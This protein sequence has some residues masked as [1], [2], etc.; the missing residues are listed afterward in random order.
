MEEEVK[1]IGFFK[2]IKISI[3][4]LEQY[5]IFTKESFSKA[6]KYLLLLVVIV[7]IILGAVSAFGVSKEIGKLISYIKTDLPD[8][9]YND[10]KL[11]MKEF[12]KAFDEEYQSRLIIDTSEE[13]AEEKIKEYRKENEDSIYSA[14]FLKDKVLFKISGQYEYEYHYTD[15]A[16]TIGLSGELT[17][18]NIID[19]YFNDN[20]ITKINVI[21]AIYAFL[22]LFI[23]N[24]LTIIED[25][26]IV[27]IFGW[28]AAKIFKVPL[29]FIK[30]ASLAIYSLTLS[31]I[32]STVYSVV[33]SFTGFEIKYFALLYM[34]VSYIY[35]VASIMMMKD[36]SDREAGEVVTV[37]GQVI[38]ENLEE[39]KEN[40]ENEKKD[41]KPDDK[42]QED[43]NSKEELPTEE[44][45]N[46]N[47]DKNDK[48]DNK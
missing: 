40:D 38:K 27:A 5:K 23:M 8:F 21:I 14:I 22:S 36:G 29:G 28:I 11:Q 41:K 2:R 7:S 16:S 44:P 4:N 48:E 26:L 6:F 42:K 43:D 17:K 12:V 19:N 9:T 33:Y 39:P 10:G 37:E 45:T 34:I 46:E 1:K 31:I 47:I 3:F 24:F 18:Q 13:V 25:V 35:M 15:L 20:G 30:T 32:L